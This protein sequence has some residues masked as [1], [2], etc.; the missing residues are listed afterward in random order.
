[1]PLRVSPAPAL[2]GKHQDGSPL[3]NRLV[4]NAM[5]AQLSRMEMCRQPLAGRPVIPVSVFFLLHANT[6]RA[7]YPSAGLE[8]LNPS[9]PDEPKCPGAQHHWKGQEWSP[10]AC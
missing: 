4:T 8:L 9:I 3:K 2:G 1:M 5:P 7:S 6:I 10:H